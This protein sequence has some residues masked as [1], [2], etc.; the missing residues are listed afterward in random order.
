MTKEFFNMY[1]NSDFVSFQDFISASKN[2]DVYIFGAGK[3]GKKLVDILKKRKISVQAVI[4]SDSSREKCSGILGIPV[5]S[6]DSVKSKDRACVFLAILNGMDVLD[7]LY[8]SGFRY[9]Y[10]MADYLVDI[11]VWLYN[12]VTPVSLDKH[13]LLKDN[14]FYEPFVGTPV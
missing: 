6:Y 2:L 14:V 3:L 4:V 10:N 7:D 8:N 9:I 11:S 13:Y 1:M 5:V 12:K